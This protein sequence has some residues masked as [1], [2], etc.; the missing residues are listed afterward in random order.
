VRTLHQ[1]F[2]L[3]CGQQHNWVLGGADLPFCQRCTGLY[4]SV[5]PA[6][7]A[8]LLCKPKPTSRILWVHG[9]FLL[10]MPPFGYHLVAQ[11]GEIR[12]L[13]GQLFAWGLVY[14]F[15]LL[16]SDRWSGWRR[17]SPL[18]N[19]SY[20]ALLGL[21]LLYLQATIAW[22]GQRTNTILSWAGSFGLLAYALLV[23]TNL[24]LLAKTAWGAM[25]GHARFSES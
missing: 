1:I 15:A 13:T 25:R 6:L 5:F 17:L 24:M 7:L 11:T 4:V 14:Y 10:A 18:G 2:S 9:I 19:K 12:M 3:V 21:W 16:P 23:L 22:G 20:F 8:Y